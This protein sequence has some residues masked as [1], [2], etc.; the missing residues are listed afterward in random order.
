[1]EDLDR[2]RIVELLTKRAESDDPALQAYFAGAIEAHCT[3]V[4]IDEPELRSIAQR[5]GFVV[6]WPLVL[7]AHVPVVAGA[8]GERPTG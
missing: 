8:I 6:D 2:D 5:Y 4:D 7:L 3:Q 1:M